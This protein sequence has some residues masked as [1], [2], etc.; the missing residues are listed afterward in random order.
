MKGTS[1]ISPTQTQSESNQ[2]KTAMRED[3]ERDLEM[4][5]S[6]FTQKK[7][8]NPL[9]Y[10]CIEGDDSVFEIATDVAKSRQL[11]DGNPCD[12]VLYY[13]SKEDPVLKKLRKQFEQQLW[14][15]QCVVKHASSLGSSTDTNTQ[16][17]EKE[18]KI[19]HCYTLVHIPY[20]RM[21]M[22]AEK[23]KLKLSLKSP[24][25]ETD[26]SFQSSSQK[27][28]EEGG[29]ERARI[30]AATKRMKARNASTASLGGNLQSYGNI[31]SMASL[32]QKDKNDKEHRT[33]TEAWDG[34]SSACVRKFKAGVPLY[35]QKNEAQEKEVVDLYKDFYAA[36]FKVVHQEKFA[37]YSPECPEMVF[38]NAQRTLLAKEFVH[39]L[40][41]MSSGNGDRDTSK[42]S[43][44]EMIK[45]GAYDGCFVLH[46]GRPKDTVQAATSDTVSK[47]PHIRSAL[48]HKWAHIGNIFKYQPIHLIREYFGEK[49][50]FY[51]AWM[52]FYVTWLIVPSLIGLLYLFYG[53]GTYDDVDFSEKACASGKHLCSTTD[54]DLAPDTLETLGEQCTGIKAATIFDNELTVPYSIFLALWTFLLLEFWKRTTTFYAFHWNVIGLQNQ[55]TNRVQ[56]YGTKE[57]LN[58]VTG[59]T[60]VVY[61]ASKR[62]RKYLGSFAVITLLTGCVIITLIAII[63]YRLA[64]A[65][66]ESTGKYGEDNSDGRLKANL[67]AS[68]LNFVAIV[69]LGAIYRKVAVILNDWENHRTAS[70]YEEHL[71]IKMFCFE[72]VNS[73]ASLFY[74]AFFKGNFTGTPKDP[75]KLFGYRNEAC[76]FY[77]CMAD[78]TVQMAIIFL[79][80]QS[81]RT[82][83]EVALPYARYKWATYR[84]GATPKDM[85][86]QWDRDYTLQPFIGM[87]R[88]YLDIVLQ[89]GYLTM[90]AAAFPIAPFIALIANACEIRVDAMKLLTKTRR[91]AAMRAESIGLWEGLL[92]FIAYAGILTNGALIAF[93]SNFVA[94]LVWDDE[95]YNRVDYFEGKYAYTFEIGQGLG[96]YNGCYYQAYRDESGFK[97]KFF[98]QL[99]SAQFIFFVAWVG[100]VFF[101]H[102]LI[103][104]WT[105]RVPKNI[106][107]AMRIQ[108]YEADLIMEDVWLDYDEGELV[109]KNE[110]TSG[111]VGMKGRRMS[112]NT[113]AMRKRYSL[114]SDNGDV[115]KDKEGVG[116]VAIEVVEDVM[117]EK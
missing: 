74:I 12:I 41:T 5:T 103:H 105:P 69:I 26:T 20:H 64:L 36:N 59:E 100:F 23:L 57:T 83:K 9:L 21:A 109:E 14:L 70:L 102:L 88:E 77:G 60:E 28:D 96:G 108:A 34:F 112:R 31:K 72:F 44:Q 65:S 30:E 2:E 53:L 55:E 87:L 25:C 39:R 113:G 13:N 42:I 115:C 22:L 92:K 86:A 54:E 56:Y 45:K 114:K 80:K 38:S 51:F 82:L 98:Y 78:L 85:D 8:Q 71:I 11:I 81:I 4:A 10:H 40:H 43:Y 1:K 24:A 84:L 29:E 33:W 106:E 58:P 61:P 76:P 68:V 15:K 48:Y 75:I 110:K 47:Y 73:Y 67:S 79:G 17:N 37:G 90:F 116:E 111:E 93:R 32:Q 16:H 91:P 49:I 89:F 99:L 97:T 101:M 63:V 46:T 95:G 27:N 19:H 117:K 66:S 94:L 104:H 50:A 62:L 18:G 7:Q 35:P 107:L 3:A 52:G 6:S